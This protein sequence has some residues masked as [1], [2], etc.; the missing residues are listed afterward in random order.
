MGQP[1]ISCLTRLEF[2]W[3]S[4]L[5]FVKQELQCN[6]HKIILVFGLK[7]SLS[8]S[9]DYIRYMETKLP[10]QKTALE[11]SIPRIP[12]PSTYATIFSCHIDQLMPMEILRLNSF[13]IFV[14]R[15]CLAI[16]LLRFLQYLR[17]VPSILTKLSSIQRAT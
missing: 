12:I 16:G 4:H 10:H 13:F 1:Q 14:F 5:R 17:W 15:G 7:I 3:L 8:S 9:F 2:L 11:C 6:F